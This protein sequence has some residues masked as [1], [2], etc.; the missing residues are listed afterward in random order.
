MAFE[1]H[2]PHLNATGGTPDQAVA[3]LM[4]KHPERFP[5]PTNA[6]HTSWLGQMPQEGT[7]APSP[8]ERTLTIDRHGAD[9]YKA[10]LTGTKAWGAGK[11][12]LEAIGTFVRDNPELLGIEIAYT[13]YAASII[14]QALNRHD[15][16]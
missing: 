15:S 16:I 1:R 11:S 4:S 8:V 10:T 13:P 6:I 5:N 14:S 9:G 12:Y 2:N 3:A 7:T